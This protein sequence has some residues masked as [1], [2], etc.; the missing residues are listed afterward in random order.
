[1]QDQGMFRFLETQETNRLQEIRQWLP[2]A[3]KCKNW[4]E[5]SNV[6]CCL[7][8]AFDAVDAELVRRA[9]ES[10]IPF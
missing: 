4:E 1:M 7:A 6:W 5:G 2:A 3:V 9:Y 8:I 10:T